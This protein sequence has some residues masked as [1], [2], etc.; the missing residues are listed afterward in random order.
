MQLSYVVV[1]YVTTL[2][3]MHT[4]NIVGGDRPPQILGV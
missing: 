2:D 1:D 4:P 3:Y